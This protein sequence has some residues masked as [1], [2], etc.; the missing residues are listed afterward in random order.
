VNE[1]SHIISKKL[2]YG[3]LELLLVY[4]FVRNVLAAAGKP[5]WYDELLTLTVSFQ[6]SWKNIIVAL[7]A[8]LDAQP[9]LF[10]VIENFAS[11]LLH[12][13]EIALRLP[14]VLAFLCTLACVFVYARKRNGE[15]IALLCTFFLLM[16][17]LFHHYA[18]EARPYSLAVACIAFALVCYQRVPS[19]FWT[20]MFA[21]ILALGES[22]HYYLVFAFVPFVGAELVFLLREGKFRWQVWAALALGVAPLL[23]FWPLLSSQKNYY[24]QHFWGH[25]SLFAIPE[26]YGSFLTTGGALGFATLAVC[27]V[28]VIATRCLSA[29]LLPGEDGGNKDSIEGTLLVLLVALPITTYILTKALHGPMQER[30]VLPTVL[31]LSLGMGCVL[32]FARMR[33]M[34]L[35]SFFILM[36]VGI[37]EVSF[38][39]SVRSPRLDNPAESVENFVQKVGYP[40]LPVVLSNGLTFVQFTH[41]E[42]PEWKQR[43][44]FPLDEQK[45]LQYV[46]TDSMSKNLKIFRRYTPQPMPDL[47]EFTI[48]NPTFLLYHEEPIHGS[49]WLSKYLPS[50]SSMQILAE[51]GNQ[52]VYLVNMKEGSFN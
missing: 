8:H 23:I 42:S 39:R 19:L 10:Y 35:A 37:H 50:V 43:F 38:W 25:F 5:L 7:R 44:L 22:L 51:D 28:G 18:I 31:G 9:P 14:S 13:Q 6:G 34:V 26:I 33:G 1:P 32:K 30:F 47:T 45:E 49:D 3:L 2:T 40:D 12:N 21:I 15:V 48:S 52:V 46:G 16:T 29:R 41:Y 27:L 20:V 17:D 36:C 24:G 11:H 4:S